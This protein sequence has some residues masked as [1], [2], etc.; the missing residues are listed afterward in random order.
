MIELCRARV[1]DPHVTYIQTDL[2]GGSPP[3]HTTCVSSASGSPTGRQ[4]PRHRAGLTQSPSGLRFGQ[5]SCKGL[6]ERL[7][8]YR[9]R[10][11]GLAGLIVG[12]LALGAPAWA[13]AVAPPVIEGESVSHVTPT[14]ATLEARIAPGA[15]SAA[16][17]QFQI[18][19]DPGEYRSEIACPLRDELKATD[20]CQGPEVKGAMIGFIPSGSGARSV[21]LELADA[22]RE[23][24]PGTTYHYRVLAVTEIQ[25]KIRSSGKRRRSTVSIRRSRHPPSLR[26]IRVRLAPDPDRCDAGSADRYRGSCDQLPVQALVYLW[27]KG[28]LSDRHPLPVAERHVAR[29]LW[30]RA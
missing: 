5:M 4:P 9:W 26:S 27:R 3:G 23:L 13:L 18:V 28:S 21:S 30:T 14:A 12:C 22:G 17:Y 2:F 6:L 24:T 10:P 25:T 1:N 8:G 11:V 7:R 15:H 16:Y 20:G 29:L 19:R